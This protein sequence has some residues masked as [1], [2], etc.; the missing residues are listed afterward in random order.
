M[1][2][3]CCTFTVFP[4]GFP[5]ADRAR[6]D[7]SR[8][9]L[10]CQRRCAGRFKA[11][12][13]TS[14]RHNIPALPTARC[15]ALPNGAARIFFRVRFKTTTKSYAAAIQRIDS[16]NKRIHRR[17]KSSSP[18]PGSRASLPIHGISADGSALLLRQARRSGDRYR[19]SARELIRSWPSRLK[20][21]RACP[22]ASLRYPIQAPS[23]T[24]A[25]YQ[26][27]RLMW[28]TCCYFVKHVQAELTTHGRWKRSL[29]TSPCPGHHLQM[30]LAQN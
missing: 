9:S 8:Q 6:A 7:R 17:W 1:A 28:H 5:K 14:S 10:I 4:A 12:V 23:H 21:C 2:S 11:C 30:S 20:A 3:P 16:R 29:F 22:M 18:R 27:A 19:I 26:V 25:Y 24:T 15:S 13:S